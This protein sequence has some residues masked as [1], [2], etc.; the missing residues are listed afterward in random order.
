MVHVLQSEWNAMVDGLNALRAQLATIERDTL[1]RARAAVMSEY[2]AVEKWGTHGTD[3]R[4][5]VL[6][7]KVLN[8]LSL[9]IKALD[10]LAAAK[11]M[12][13]P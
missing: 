6:H 7:N 10:A 3:L 11:T 13:H 12:E 9:A 4:S 5:Q 1:S 8:G 2:E